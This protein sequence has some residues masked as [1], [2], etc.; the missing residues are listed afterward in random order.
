MHSNDF[1]KDF[2]NLKANSVFMKTMKMKQT[3]TYQICDNQKNQI[4]IK[5]DGFQKTC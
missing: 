4:I 1:E 3:L 2:Y 5:Q